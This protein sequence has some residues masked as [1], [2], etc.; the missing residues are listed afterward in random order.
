[1]NGRRGLEHDRPTTE[2][3][4]NCINI[5]YRSFTGRTGAAPG[6]LPVS[7]LEQ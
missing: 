5:H 3:A 7:D 1:V 6:I 2:F 4:D